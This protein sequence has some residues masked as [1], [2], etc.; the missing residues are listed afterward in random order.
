MQNRKW[1]SG[2]CYRAKTLALA[3][4]LALADRGW[5]Q[6]SWTA[7]TGNWFNSAN[8]SA[9]VP[10]FFGT[11]EIN[12]GGTAQIGS[13]NT[14]PGSLI[15]GA[16]AGESGNVVISG[17]ELTPQEED[18][19]VSGSG[20]I[21][22]TGGVNSGNIGIGGQPSSFGGGTGSYLLS[23]GRLDS[24][25]ESIG[26]G[27]SGTFTQT[28]GTNT[29]SEGGEIL[30]GSGVSNSVGTGSYLLQAGTLGAAGAVEDIGVGGGL[31]SSPGTSSG[32][33]DQSGGSN[34]ANELRIGRG[35][36]NVV[37]EYVLS[38]GQL[39]VNQEEDLG[40]GA[41]ST[42]TF[43]QTGG[44]NTT[45]T[46]NLLN[47]G[48]SSAVQYDLSGGTLSVNN[49]LLY[50]GGMS[51]SNTTADATSVSNNALIRLAGSNGASSAGNL[52]SELFYQAPT[53]ELDIGIGGATSGTQYG[54]LTVS[55]EA[56]LEGTLGISLTNGFVPE[57]GEQ[58][59]IIT[60]SALGGTFSTINLPG[61]VSFSV[62][63][64]STSV[65]LT[66]LPE[67]TSLSLLALSGV[68]FLKRNPHH[69]PTISPPRPWTTCVESHPS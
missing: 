9:G 27:G 65:T 53:A 28:G 5:G 62:A 35:A 6:T 61:N 57:I 12:N 60:G 42:A 59:D 20:A 32:T 54:V 39:T 24:P 26:Y 40:Q 36:S 4:V 13:G 56:A 33:F 46:L 50:E 18:V 11:A 66:A 22:Q 1:V 45:P 3:A 68:V 15:L 69:N 30:V 34:L 14:A 31:S 63:Y 67:P 19:G 21:E 8:W 16:A 25:S 47:L 44:S 48:N 38:A 58:F 64:S 10:S 55:G 29:N 23:A 17:G 37:G 7:A 41:K 52:S 49:L 51:I 2:K 43:I